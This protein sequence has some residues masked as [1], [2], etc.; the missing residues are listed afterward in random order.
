MMRAALAASVMV[1]AGCVTGYHAI[2][3]TGGYSEMQLNT[4]TFQVRFV[5]NMN[6]DPGLVARLV[7]RRCAEITLEHGRR[8]FLIQQ[9]SRAAWETASDAQATMTILDAA[10][11]PPSAADAAV[12]VRETDLAAGGQLSR[13]ARETLAKLGLGPA[14]AP[15]PASVH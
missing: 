6:S 9:E 11:A 1:L 14:P 13:A 8:Y 15:V 12:V 2:D 3:P 10:D 4:N 5:G 7:L